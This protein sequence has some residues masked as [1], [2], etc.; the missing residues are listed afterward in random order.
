[1]SSEQ[2]HN[3]YHNNNKSWE[4]L[5]QLFRFFSTFKGIQVTFLTV[6]CGIQK[7]IFSSNSKPHIKK[8][9]KLNESN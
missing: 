4:A 6:P 7:H 9:I 1:M 2:L 5:S 8:N 3:L